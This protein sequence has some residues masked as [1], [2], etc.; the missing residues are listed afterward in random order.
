MVLNIVTRCVPRQI[1][2][3][4]T[5]SSRCTCST[6]RTAIFINNCERLSTTGQIRLGV[7]SYSRNI[8]AYRARV[9]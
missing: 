1:H 5:A 4:H 7:H 2:N 3:A 9:R 8:I 6:S